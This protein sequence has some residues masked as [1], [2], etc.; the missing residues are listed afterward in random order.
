MEYSKKWKV[1]KAFCDQ[2]Q[3]QENIDQ[4]TIHNKIEQKEIF[5]S[6]VEEFQLDALDLQNYL[7]KTCQFGNKFDIYKMRTLKRNENV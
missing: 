4:E 2:L 7:N 6:Y 5:F 3:L 1:I